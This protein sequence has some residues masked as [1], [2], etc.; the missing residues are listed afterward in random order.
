MIFRAPWKSSFAGF[1]ERALAR[2]ATANLGSGKRPNPPR[3]IVAQG[4]SRKIVVTWNSD[5]NNESNV[6]YRVYR[7]TESELYREC[8]EQHCEVSCSTSATPALINIFVSAIT[9]TGI[10][11]R[12]VLVQC[13]PAAE[14][15][16]PAEPSPPAGWSR[17]PTGG[18]GGGSR[19]GGGGGRRSTM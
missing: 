12:K 16:A 1:R 17:E 14:A 15:G 4:G 10:E 2:D 18:S 13:A 9:P 8:V 11:S 3:S 5:P 6:R 7:N 19:S